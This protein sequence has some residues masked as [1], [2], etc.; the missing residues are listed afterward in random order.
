MKKGLLV[1][2]V[3]ALTFALTA[4]LTVLAVDGEPTTTQSAE[5]KYEVIISPVEIAAGA[6][7]GMKGNELTSW[8][9]TFGADY[10][11]VFVGDARVIDKEGKVVP[12][13]NTLDPEVTGTFSASDYKGDIIAHYGTHG[14][15]QG[16]SV[17]ISSK[18]MS[19]VIVLKKVSESK[20]PNTGDSNNNVLWISALVIALVC[21]GAA[22]A[23]RK[24]N[25]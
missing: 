6:K 1:A 23:M 8:P 25:A 13:A 2:A 22:F 11:V 3:A 21:G 7:I 10:E 19:P 12:N 15:D 17:K 20:V 14:V 9:V 5:K 4:P 18:D 16:A 24:S